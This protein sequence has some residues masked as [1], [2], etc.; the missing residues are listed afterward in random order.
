MIKISRVGFSRIRQSNV[1]A[2]DRPLKMRGHFCHNRNRSILPLL[3]HTG[4]EVSFGLLTLCNN[5][6]HY[7]MMRAY[8]HVLSSN[9]STDG[10]DGVPNMPSSMT[11]SKRFEADNISSECRNPWGTKGGWRRRMVVAVVWR[12][13]RKW[14]KGYSHVFTSN[15]PVADG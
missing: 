8:S 14:M 7:D 4:I 2:W 5:F 3:L 9:F 13:T 1:R 10:C 15:F 12:M 6:H 11:S